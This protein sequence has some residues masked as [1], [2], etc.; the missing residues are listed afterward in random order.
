MIIT[1]KI[2]IKRMRM[3]LRLQLTLCSIMITHPK[4]LS[5]RSLLRQTPP[6]IFS[7]SLPNEI[8]ISNI[9]NLNSNHSPRSLKIKINKK[10]IWLKFRISIIWIKIL[11]NSLNHR[12]LT[13]NNLRNQFYLKNLLR[14]IP[15]YKKKIH[16]LKMENKNK[17]IK[18]NNYKI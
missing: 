7:N 17:K 4:C 8:S 14:I 15:F 13:R 10:I 1:R 11:L 3:F 2:P 5:S 18:M 6:T 16:R 12:S 9:S